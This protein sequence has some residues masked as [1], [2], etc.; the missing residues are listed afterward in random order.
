MILSADESVRAV[1]AVAAFADGKT[2]QIYIYMSGDNVTLSCDTAE[3][4]LD[5]VSWEG[6]DHKVSVDAAALADML[7]AFGDEDVTV[8]FRDS[9]VEPLLFEDKKGRIGVLMPM[10]F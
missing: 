1:N 3:E 7:T 9:A 6:G 8:T 5:V 2:K 4:P 10:R